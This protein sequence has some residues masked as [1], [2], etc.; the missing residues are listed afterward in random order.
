MQKSLYFANQ[1]RQILWFGGAENI[2]HSIRLG[3]CTVHAHHG[4]FF[5]LRW[6]Q[7]GSVS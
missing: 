4:T 5:Y 1:R 6:E 2:A 7:N 3:E